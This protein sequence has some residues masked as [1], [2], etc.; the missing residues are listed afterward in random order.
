MATGHYARIGQQIQSSKF[1]VQNERFNL[2]R[3]IDPDKDQSY[4]LSA[5]SSEQLQQALFPIGGLQKSEVREM[6]RKAG[7][8]NAERKDSQG[9]CFVGKVDFAQFLKSHIPAQTGDIV[10]TQ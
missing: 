10:D 7:L 1:K 9:L 8:P 5:L 4:F 6:A 3:G 2:L